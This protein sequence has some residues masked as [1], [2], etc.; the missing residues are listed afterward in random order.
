MEKKKRKIFREMM[1]EHTRDVALFSKVFPM[2][3]FS[4]GKRR[5]E[6]KKSGESKFRAS[7][8]TVYQC[9]NPRLASRISSSSSS[10][11]TWLGCHKHTS[12]PLGTCV[13]LTKGSFLQ[14]LY[15]FAIHSTPHTRDIPFL[16]SSRPNSSHEYVV[17]SSVDA[18]QSTH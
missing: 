14:I 15:V 11:L 10:T 9:L 16:L 5:K 4:L 7:H 17:E 13:G 18:L 12:S 8:S 6:K 3:F 1:V 2:R